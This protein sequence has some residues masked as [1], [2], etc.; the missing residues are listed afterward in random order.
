MVDGKAQAK[1]DGRHISLEL[2]RGPTRELPTS[3]Q[4]NESLDV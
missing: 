1:Q 2:C 3:Q 4:I